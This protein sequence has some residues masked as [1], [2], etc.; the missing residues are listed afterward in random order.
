MS[1]SA[2]RSSANRCSCSVYSL[3]SDMPLI[4]ALSVLEPIPFR[5]S[6][7]LENN[8]V[9]I[10]SGAQQGALES[11]NET[12]QDHENHRDH[13]DPKGR[14]RGGCAPLEQAADIVADGNHASLLPRNPH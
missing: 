8:P 2:V 7:A 11:A 3:R 6:T 14:H 9:V 5:Q 4:I 1:P 10:I 12:E 13:G